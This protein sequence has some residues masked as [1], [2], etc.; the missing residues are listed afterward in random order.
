M[1]KRCL[2]IVA[3]SN[4]FLAVPTHLLARFSMR[5]SMGVGALMGNPPVSTAL[6][7]AVGL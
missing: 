6:L 7:Q 3:Q 2:R 4:G 5:D 1:A